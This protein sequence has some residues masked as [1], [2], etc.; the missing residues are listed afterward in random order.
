M[1]RVRL[2]EVF[3]RVCQRLELE[4]LDTNAVHS[5]CALTEVVQLEVYRCYSAQQ[6]CV[7]H[8]VL[9]YEFTHRLLYRC[10]L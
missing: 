10:M 8:Y 1:P 2:V 4:E 6:D 5:A 3:A 7:R 9:V